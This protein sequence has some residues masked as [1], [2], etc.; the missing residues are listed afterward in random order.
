MQGAFGD[1]ILLMLHCV[2]GDIIFFG[3]YAL[4]SLLVHLWYVIVVTTGVFGDIKFGV[5]CVHM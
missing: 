2:F 5:V 3:L 1:I 4:G